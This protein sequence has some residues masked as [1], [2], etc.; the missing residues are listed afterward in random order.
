[1]EQDNLIGRTIDKYEIIDQIARG[2]MATVYKAR[3]PS[4][5]R[6]VA[7]KVI[8]PEY[9]KDPTLMQRFRRE[10][11]LIAELQHPHILP[12]YDYGEIDGRPYIVMAYMPGGSV[13]DLIVAPGHIPLETVNR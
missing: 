7:I 6:T 1:M 13:H 5:G 10:V 4:I 11:E 8:D 9:A 2:G 3:Q 12:V